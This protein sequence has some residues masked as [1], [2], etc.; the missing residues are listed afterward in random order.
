MVAGFHVAGFT[1]K[2]QVAFWFVRNVDEDRQTLFGELKFER[3]SGDAM[4]HS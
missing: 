3:T 4:H 2:G 1:G